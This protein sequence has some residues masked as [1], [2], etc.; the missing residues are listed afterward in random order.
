[1]SAREL[2]AAG[3]AGPALRAAYARCRRLNA[4]NGKTYFLATRLLTPRQRPAVHA[5]YGFARF[6]DDIVD[7]LAALPDPRLRARALAELDGT[8]RAALR[9]GRSGHPVLAAL[10]DTVRRYRIDPGHFTDF[11]RSMSMDLHVT[12]YATFADLH[13]YMHGS[14]AV[15]GLQ[16]LPVLDTVVPRAEAAPHA[17]SLGVAFQLTNFLRDVG[18]DLDRDRVYLPQD[19]LAAHG[20]DR[21]LLLWCRRTGHTDVRVRAALRELIGTTRGIYRHAAAGIPMLHPVSRPCVRTAFILYHAILSRIEA[22]DCAVIHRRTV[23]PRR[24]RA[25]VALGGLAG[26]AASRARGA[27]TADQPRAGRTEGALS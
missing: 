20:V 4:R 6:A 11:M 8:L 16:V 27:L 19:R 5:L 12:G 18:E 15:I 9:T 10:A 7:D 3:V 26:I 22:A 2:D 24:H 23:V 17:A 13:T 1:M 25:G 14:A 21:D